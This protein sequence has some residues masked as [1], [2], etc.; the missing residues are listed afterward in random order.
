VLGRVKS[1]VVSNVWYSILTLKLTR[2]ADCN[3]LHLDLTNIFDSFLP[4][5]LLYPNPSDP[6]N[7]EA[8]SLML[9]DH[10]EYVKKI[11][12]IDMDVVSSNLGFF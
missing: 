7:G 12:G 4:Q 8:A 9:R 10:N 11:R 6:L 2:I 1:N 3:S 5:L